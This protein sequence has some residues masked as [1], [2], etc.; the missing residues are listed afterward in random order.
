MVRKV[1]AGA[2]MERGTGHHPEP[3]G[4]WPGKFLSQ[5]F[6]N[7]FLPKIQKGMIEKCLE[8]SA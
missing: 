4:P 1:P 7:L 8:I 3:P 6:Q 2:G 5:I